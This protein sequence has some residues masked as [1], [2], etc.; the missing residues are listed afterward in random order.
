MNNPFPYSFDNKR[1]HTWN[2]YLKTHYGSKV[3]KVPLN[4]GFTCPN[5]DGSKGLGGCTFC[6]ALGSGEFQ[7]ITKDS[8][9]QQ[10]ESG[11]E[12]MHRKWPD[13]KLMAYFQSYTNTYGP[14][15]KIKDCVDPF[16]Y[17]DDVIGICIATRA[18]CLEKD[19]I[20]YLNECAETKDIWIEL[21]L[22]SIHDE[23]A[24]RI[25]RGHTY[26]EFKD[27]VTEL[28]HT[29]LKICVH[30]MNSLPNET[31]EMMIETAKEVGMLPI[32][33]VKIHMLHLIEH[34]VMHQQWLKEPF[35]L[36]SQQEYVDITVKQLRHLPA[37]LIIQRVTGDGMKESL[38]EP[39]WTL[40]KTQVTNDIDKLMA[41]QCVMQGDLYEQ[42]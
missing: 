42:R 10:F 40:N 14:L 34:T 23:T 2:Y 25:N 3:C 37:H 13:A 24:K 12:I 38:V 20:D 11:A 1:Y 22:Q 28:Q 36:L 32:H 29:K 7:G 26:Q 27:K 5:R 35:H 33:A 39:K 41:S 16:L 15:Q 9:I 4:A 6:S 8:L 30:L 21:G 17:R 31:E 18:D 19:V